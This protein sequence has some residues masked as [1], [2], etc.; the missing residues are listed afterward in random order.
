[1]REEFVIAFMSSGHHVDMSSESVGTVARFLTLHNSGAGRI[2]DRGRLLVLES[3]GLTFDAFYVE[4]ENAK[5]F[6]LLGAHGTAGG[7]GA[8]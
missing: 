5:R 4:R 8:E 3:G 6:H 1:M 2:G 7:G